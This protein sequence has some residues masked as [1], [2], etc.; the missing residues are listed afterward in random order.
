MIKTAAGLLK[1]LSQNGFRRCSESWKA[2]IYMEQSVLSNGN[3][4]ELIQ[5]THNN[6]VLPETSPFI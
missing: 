4:F 6:Y 5:C 1:G 2:Y 3:Y